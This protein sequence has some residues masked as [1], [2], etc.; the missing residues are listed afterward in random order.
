LQAR[1]KED[2]STNS[3][4][5]QQLSPTTDNNGIDEPIDFEEKKRIHNKKQ[6]LKSKHKVENEDL[7]E[8]P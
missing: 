2:S 5:R 6:T 1:D 8:N 7:E 3:K 4:S